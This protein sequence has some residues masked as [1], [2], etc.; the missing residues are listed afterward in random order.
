MSKIIRN[1]IIYSAAL[2]DAYNLATHLA[3]LPY[4]PIGETALSRASFIPNRVSNELVTEFQG[5]YSFTLRY[6]EK[7]LPK[8]IVREM[9]KQRIA[10]IELLSGER[11]GKVERLAVIDDVFVTLA[12]TALVKTAIIT[13]FYH[14]ADKYLIVP[15]SNKK[16]AGV[17]ISNLIKVTGSV[18]TTTIHIDDIKNGL[19]T[20]LKAHLNGMHA[21]FKEEGFELGE[22][23]SLTKLSEHARYKLND[24]STAKDGILDRLENGFTVNTLSLVSNEVEFKMTSDFAFKQMQFGVEI[25]VDEGDDAVFLWKQEA[26][27]QVLLFTRVIRDLC[28]LLGYKPPVEEDQPA[29]EQAAE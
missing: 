24:L 29:L 26:S 1:A 10:T 27:V 4:E 8:T 13:A 17:V 12:K 19:T 16:L 3:E 15:V 18:K 28:E 5:G 2:P 22:E 11:L 7:I 9:A 14:A 20:R 23:V 21:A 6:D 25:E